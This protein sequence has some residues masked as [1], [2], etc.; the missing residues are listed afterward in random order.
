MTRSDRKGFT[1]IELTVAMLVAGLVLGALYAA[2]VSTAQTNHRIEEE[3]SASRVGPVILDLI[4]RD[5]EGCYV[6]YTEEI[7][8]RGK[9]AGGSATAKDRIDFVTTRNS[10][11]PVEEE[12][13]R[14]LLSRDKKRARHADYN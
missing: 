2:M 6:P 12:E 8:F 3:L 7:F 4:T 10:I 11:L 1:L 14:T 5:L 13:F 9:D